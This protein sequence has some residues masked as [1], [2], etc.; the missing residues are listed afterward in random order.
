MYNG[1]EVMDMANY[2]QVGSSGSKVKELQE[3]LN[4]NGYNLSVDGVYGSAT[5]NAV[6]KYQKANGLGVDGIVGDETWGKLTGGGNTAVDGSAQTPTATTPLGTTYNPNETTGNKAD[7]NAVEGM[8]PTFQQTQAYKDALAALQGHQASQPGAYV[9][10]FADRLNALYDKVMNRPGFSY[11]FNADPIYQHYNDRYTLNAKRAMQDTM[12][13]AA[14]LSGGYGNSYAQTA[15]QQAYA[16]TMQGLNDII[17]TLHADA[18][19]RYQQEG[20]DLINQLQL[21]QGMDETEYGRYRDTLDDYYTKLNYLYGAAEDQYNKDY[22]VY[23]DALNAWL[24]NRDYYYGKVQDDIALEQATGGKSS[25]GGS[26]SSKS[27]SGTDTKNS[28]DNKN[29]GKDTDKNTDSSADT[30]NIFEARRILNTI[31]KE[32]GIEEAKRVMNQLINDKR[33]TGT[34]VKKKLQ[35]TIDILSGKGA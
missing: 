18:Y 7:L 22:A 15:G 28:T 21:T 34:D 24:N 31:Y 10:P 35:E 8:G 27:S 1:G 33:V 9:S 32:Y 6:R 16:Q 26:S 19:S 14:A 12:A 30:Y 23:Q 13:N 5:Q 11:D 4:Q 20:Q 29:T 3:L 25:G 17:P 2:L